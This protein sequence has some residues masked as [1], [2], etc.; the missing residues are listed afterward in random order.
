MFDFS[1][2]RGRFYPGICEAKE[3]RMMR[4]DEITEGSRVKWFRNKWR[5]RIKGATS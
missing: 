1:D 3:I 5:R 4:V 2:S